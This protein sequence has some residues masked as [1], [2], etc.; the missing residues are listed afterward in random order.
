MKYLL[1]LTALFMVGCGSDHDVNIE[2]SEHVA[3]VSIAQS[4]REVCEDRFNQYDYPDELE[5]DMLQAECRRRFAD[6]EEV[7]DIPELPV[8]GV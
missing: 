3:Y 1:V 4:W 6:G 8:G 2:D 5:R 7:L